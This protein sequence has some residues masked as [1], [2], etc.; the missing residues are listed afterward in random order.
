MPKIVKRNGGA[1]P[2][3]SRRPFSSKTDSQ[4]VN[5]HKVDERSSI[6]KLADY[7]T[8]A[9]ALYEMPTSRCLFCNLDRSQT[10]E[11][12]F[13]SPCKCNDALMKYV[14]REC[15][16]HWLLEQRS[17]DNIFLTIRCDNCGSPFDFRPVSDATGP[18]AVTLVES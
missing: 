10:P 3:V 13:A 1:S 7:M 18:M 15:L 12:V 14:H 8:D 2:N 11:Q 16:Q 6:P 9:G 17:G 5:F 4:Q